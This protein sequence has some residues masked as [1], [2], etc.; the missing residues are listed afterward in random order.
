LQLP[1]SP[2]EL[3]EV[4]RVLLGELVQLFAEFVMLDVKTNGQ[5]GRNEQ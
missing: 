3:R 5:K 2:L 4:L 1:D